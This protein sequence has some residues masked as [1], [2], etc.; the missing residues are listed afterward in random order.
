MSVSQNGVDSVLVSWMPPSKEIAVNGYIIYY[1]QYGAQRL[2]LSAEAIATTAT[3]TGL[4]AG[5]YFIT[6]VAT[7]STLPSNETIPQD[8]TL[9]RSIYISI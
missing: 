4:I 6:M 9:G 7:S 5:T 2:S 8:I 3:I 1:Q